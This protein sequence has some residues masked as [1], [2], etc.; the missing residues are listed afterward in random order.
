MYTSAFSLPVFF[1]PPN[2]MR[3]EQYWYSPWVQGAGLRYLSLSQDE[4]SW[5]PGPASF[6]HP[7][8]SLTGHLQPPPSAI[9]FR[10]LHVQ[11]SVLREQSKGRWGLECDLIDST[12]CVRVCVFLWFSGGVRGSVFEHWMADRGGMTP[13][14]EHQEDDRDGAKRMM[15]E[16]GREGGSFPWPLT[17]THWLGNQDCPRTHTPP[18]LPCRERRTHSAHYSCYLVG[19]LDLGQ[20]SR[21]QGKH[22]GVVHELQSLPKQVL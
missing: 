22:V 11:A 12:L 15:E 7:R 14:H 2:K 21:H 19:V 20:Y 1:L 9:Q 10:F 5:A 16:W 3:K 4:K 13:P 18:C 6:F 17:L 8:A